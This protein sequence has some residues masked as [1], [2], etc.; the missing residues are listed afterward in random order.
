MK[1]AQ[2]HEGIAKSRRILYL[3]NGQSVAWPDLVAV[4]MA[5]LFAAALIWLTFRQYATFHTQ[6]PDVAIFDDAIWNTLQGRLM[7]TSIKNRSILASHF[8]PY[9]VILSPLYLVWSDGRILYIVQVIGLAVAGL[10]LYKIVRE[11]HT[12]I[13]P[14]FLLA[15]YLNPA[16]HE[17]ALLELRRVTLAVPYL[18]LAM[19][20]L[21]VKKRRLM[22][23]GL[24][25]AV[26]C[27]E[28]IGLLVSMVGLYVLLVERDWK[29]G[30]PLI[31]FGA[32]WLVSTMLWIIPAFNPVD[33]PSGYRL[34][35][36]FSGWG[37]SFGGIAGSMFQEP[38]LLLQRLFDREAIRA[39]WRVFLPLG[40]VLPFLAP[41]WLLISIPSFMYMLASSQPN[42]HRLED[43]YMASVLPVLFAAIAIGL[44]RRSARWA[45]W[46]V[47]GLLGTTLIGYGLFSH[48]PL[49]GRFDPSNY[50]LTDHHRLAEEV[51]AAVPADARVAAQV[52]FITHVTHREHIYHYPKIP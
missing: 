32:A 52:S 7:F 38:L 11:K 45:R 19:Y 44:N 34:V 39:L 46:L 8:S 47:V 12:G 15:Y 50:I 1:K 18:A 28:N 26:L 6:G 24:F 30:A 22:I 25:L 17:I 3:G 13:A 5:V 33:A 37:D 16:L 4:A 51:V 21:Y 20:A 35:K 40:V 42:M 14:W 29:W 27:K 23:V 10:L 48:A 41:D 2:G 31:I 36:Y 9:M 43:W 49:G